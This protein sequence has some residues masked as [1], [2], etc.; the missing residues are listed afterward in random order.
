MGSLATCLLTSSNRA[1]AILAR[2][3]RGNLTMVEKKHEN[4]H[5]RH[6]PEA[7]KDDRPNH[8]LEDDKKPGAGS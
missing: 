4:M 2:L 6:P 5:P 7:H 3:N 8:P 1:R